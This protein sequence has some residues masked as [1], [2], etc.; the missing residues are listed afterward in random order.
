MAGEY[1][2]QWEPGRSVVFLSPV[3]ASTASGLIQSQPGV[4]G[5]LE[6]VSLISHTSGEDAKKIPG[7]HLGQFDMQTE[8]SNLHGT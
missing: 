7:L 3:D 6:V 4:R 8:Q 1:H 2:G 5:K